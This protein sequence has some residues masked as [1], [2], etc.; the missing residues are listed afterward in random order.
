MFSIWILVTTLIVLA[1]QS[2]AW[3]IMRKYGF[4]P[5][6]FNEGKLRIMSAGGR[7]VW[8][9]SL[10]VSGVL[11]ANLCTFLPAACILFITDSSL[12]HGLYHYDWIK[13]EPFWLY[14]IP[15]YG[16]D[17]SLFLMLFAT[18][19]SPIWVAL[20]FIERNYLYLSGYSISVFKE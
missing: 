6:S 7:L 1:G 19:Y 8:R 17:I 13:I 5:L 2:R 20:H 12:F 15:L 3:S 14:Y 9:F 18:I 11:I 10:F 16:G 4:K